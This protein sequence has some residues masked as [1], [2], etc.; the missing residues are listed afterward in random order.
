MRRIWF[1]LIFLGPLA[2]TS[3]VRAWGYFGHRQINKQAAQNLNGPFGQFVKNYESALAWYG[4]VPDY[5]KGIDHNEFPRHF[6]DADLYDSFPFNQIPAD[7]DSLLAKYGEENVLKW[8]YLPWVIQTT[9]ERIIN[10]LKQERFEEAIYHMG[11]L[12]H[13]VSDLHNP[14]H[15][16]KNYNGQ[17]T[18]NKGVHFRWEGRLV[19]E[20]VNVI[21][22]SPN[23]IMIKDP[24]AAA[25]DILRNSFSL[26]VQIMD[27]DT[28][29]RKILT[30]EQIKE[31]DS[32]KILPFEEPYLQI[33]YSETKDLLHSQLGGAVTS[34]ADYWLYCYMAAGSPELPD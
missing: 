34:I 16:I 20:Y 17:F 9:C 18:G 28:K 25:F 4:P 1:I 26:H 33:L 3:P 29:A 21:T 27:A 32:Y 6:M 2:L 19:K 5:L 14:L 13:Y 12:G 7:Y 15:T 11:A 31:L 22:P 30:P 10:L 8:G 23:S 24:L